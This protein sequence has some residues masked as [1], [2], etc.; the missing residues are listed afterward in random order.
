MV[1]GPETICSWIVLGQTRAVIR[2]FTLKTTRGKALGAIRGEKCFI[3]E[4]GF[5]GMFRPASAQ[6]RRTWGKFFRNRLS[7]GCQ[8]WLGS[9]VPFFMKFSGREKFRFDSNPAIACRPGGKLDRD[10]PEI[11]PM[12]SFG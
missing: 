11:G 9:S 8:D 12:K 5:E 4:P 6:S 7:I 1:P 3:L 10:Q 2:E